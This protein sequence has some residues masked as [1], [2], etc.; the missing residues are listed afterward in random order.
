MPTVTACTHCQ[1]KYTVPETAIGKQ[2]KCAKCGQSFVVAP[3]TPG[4][5]LVKTGTPAAPPTAKPAAAAKPASTATKPPAPSVPPAANSAST[6]P[7]AAKSAAA[8]PAPAAKP[9]TKPLTEAELMAAFQGEFQ[10]VR[11]PLGYRLGIFLAAIVMVG[12]IVVY[13]AL[14]ALVAYGTYYH[15]V[16]D[17]SLAAMGGTGRG[18]LFMVLVYL[19]PIFTGMVIVFFMF[20]PLLARPAQRERS[21]S[22]TRQS[23]PLLFA[24]VD[25]ICETVGAPHPKRIDVDCQVN[26]SASF[27]R[28]LWSMFGKDLVLT[29][30]LPLMG[31]LTVQEFGG[32][33][34]H[35]FGHFTQGVGMRLTYLVQRISMWF[36]RVVYQR[37][38]WDEHLATLAGELDI[39]IGWVVMLAQLGV[40]I[41]RGVLWVLM[42]IG[43]LVSGILLRQ[44]EFDA[45]QCEAN[46][47]G[48]ASLARTM[49]KLQLL[50]AASQLAHAQAGEHLDEKRLVEDFPGLIQ[51]NTR[52]LP[53]ELVS[54][55]EKAVAE[56]KTGWFDTHPSDRERI[57]AAEKLARTGIFHLQRPARE[58]MHDFTLQSKATTWDMYLALFGPKVPREA[59]V[60]VADFARA[61][62]SRWREADE[63]QRTENYRY[64]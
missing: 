50:G 44:M 34:A 22:L 37:D 4:V 35:E 36:L 12:L 9:L 16:N 52:T 59:L 23:E 14:I 15:A 47:A 8:A 24:F 38:V 43:F 49:T 6:K 30:G 48:S 18:R 63:P 54:A 64:E 61:A 58:L 51:F 26:A 17:T 3:T 41:G 29:I 1:A 40:L 10:R 33:L 25:R 56:S 11:M 46:F 60:P 39:R 20:K 28:G 5:G 31:G 55:A 2:A 57:A 7:A 62:K 45:D 53:P 13:L 19:A 42:H 21:R 27:R 32:V